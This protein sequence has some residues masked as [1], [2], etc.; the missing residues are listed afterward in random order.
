MILV[1]LGTNYFSFDRLVKEIDNK[2]SLNNDVE[3]QLGNT[4][5][6]PKNCKYFIFEAR[7]KLI[8]RMRKADLIITQGGYGGMMDSM[9]LKK[10]IIAVPR[11]IDLNECLDDQKELVRYFE[12]KNYLVGCYEITDLNALVDNVMND[13][14]KF[15]EYRPESNVKIKD[16]I[17]EDIVE[18]LNVKE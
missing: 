6:I 18:M 8:E 1:L 5:Y 17:G 2:I 3:I 12:E 13:K 14:I 9:Q 11:K 10:K 16:L 15:L 4:K 7:D